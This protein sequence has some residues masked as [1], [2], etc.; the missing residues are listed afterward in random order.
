MIVYLSREETRNERT[1]QALMEMAGA[2]QPLSPASRIESA[3]AVIL[4]ALA[5]IH[6][7]EF[8]AELDHEIGFLLFRRNSGSTR[9][10]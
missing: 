10:G 6:G 7:E 5:E 1:V 3:S 4:S 8:R 2:S 9:V